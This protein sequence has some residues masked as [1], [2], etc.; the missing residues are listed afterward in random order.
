M[1]ENDAY[2][3]LQ[4]L[5]DRLAETHTPEMIDDLIQDAFEEWVEE[6]FPHLLEDN[7]DED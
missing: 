6:N 2:V 7:N 5:F 1:N 3:A 4:G